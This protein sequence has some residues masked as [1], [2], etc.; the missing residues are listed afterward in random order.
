MEIGWILGSPVS[1][2]S[3]SPRGEDQKLE[4]EKE[5]DFLA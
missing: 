5:I 2:L 3:P 4:D 1:N